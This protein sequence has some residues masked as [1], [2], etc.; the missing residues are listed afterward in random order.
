MRKERE[1]GRTLLVAGGDVDIGGLF[2]RVVL[3]GLVLL[4]GLCGGVC[5]CGL[6][7][8]GF[9]LLLEGLLCCE[10]LLLLD[11]LEGRLGEGLA[12]GVELLVGRGRGCGDLGDGGSE[13]GC[14]VAHGAGAGR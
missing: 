1:G 4:G 2:G 14:R 3:L 13:C 7:G 6:G 12:V 9:L 10:G 11:A 8:S 5:W